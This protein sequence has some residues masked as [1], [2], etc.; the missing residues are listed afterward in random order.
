ID[1]DS[2]GS[3]LAD[4]SEYGSLE[5]RLIRREHAAEL[6]AMIEALP[7]RRRDVL[8]LRYYGELRNN[9]IAQV[10]GI[11]ERT[12]SSHLSRGLR[13][14]HDAYTAKFKEAEEIHDEQ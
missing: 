14:L 10:M 3:D 1:L 9:E 12:V 7:L 5:L 8:M 6:R 2:S 4:E 11:D 13:D